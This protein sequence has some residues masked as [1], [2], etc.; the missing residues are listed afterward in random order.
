MT[1]DL[2][3]GNREGQEQ[4]AVAKR[5]GDGRWGVTKVAGEGER[6]V[7]GYLRGWQG[8]QRRGLGFSV[9]LPT[10]PPFTSAAPAPSS[11]CPGPAPARAAAASFPAVAKGA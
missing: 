10:R 1:E 8:L 6:E 4:R 3:G 2:G 5:S 11:H 9:P 7:V